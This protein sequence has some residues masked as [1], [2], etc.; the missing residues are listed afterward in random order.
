MTISKIN[1]TFMV[2]SFMLNVALLYIAE[3]ISRWALKEHEK[4]GQLSER[5]I[6]WVMR[7]VGWAEESSKLVALSIL[8]V[9]P[10]LVADLIIR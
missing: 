2:V 3:L 9:L 4:S 7:L 1:F 5:A 10:A 8:L 6:I